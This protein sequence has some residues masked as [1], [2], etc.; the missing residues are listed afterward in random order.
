MKKRYIYSLLFGIPGFFVSLIFAVLISGTMAGFL[1]LF[2]FGDN[3]WP[4][5][6]E[7]ILSLIFVIG[8]VSGWGTFIVLGFM[9]GKKLE[10]EPDLNKRH[11]W[12]SAIATIVPIALIGLHQFSVGNIG[13]GPDTVLCSHFCTEKGYSASGMPPKVSGEKTCTCFGTDDKETIKVPI[14]NIE[15]EQKPAT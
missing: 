14:K 12:I 9:T 10:Q 11:I 5:Y 6:S 1:W 4:V 15:P 13:P 2:V 8:L 7:K 3:T